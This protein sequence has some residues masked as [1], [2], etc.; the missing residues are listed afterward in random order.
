MSSCLFFC[1]AQ[2]GG[3]HWS[4]VDV[5]GQRSER[6]KWLNCFDNV[7]AIIYVVNLAGYCTVLFE[8]KQVIRMHESL[9][10]FEQTMANPLFMHIPVFLFLNKKDL[11]EQMIREKPIQCCFPEYTGTNELRDCIDFI[12]TQYQNRLPNKHSR[13]T[14]LLLAARVRKDVRFCFEEVKDLLLAANKKDIAKNQSALDKQQ[15]YAI[16]DAKDAD[17]T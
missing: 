7:K 2:T 15:K 16:E 3:V 17:E 11:F 8:D 5:G 1:I 9:N 12:A 4:C 14:V 13:A 6:R 10:L